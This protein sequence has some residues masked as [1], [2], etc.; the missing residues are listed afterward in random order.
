LRRLQTTLDYLHEK[1]GDLPL[2][3]YD[4]EAALRII[5]VP[6][7]RLLLK[8]QGDELVI[9]SVLASFRYIFGDGPDP[10]KYEQRQ[11]LSESQVFSPPSAIN[12]PGASPKAN[13]FP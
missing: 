4:E 12:K 8:V 3:L 1:L 7:V 5:E 6:N 10:I 2:A 11:L 9:T 13:S